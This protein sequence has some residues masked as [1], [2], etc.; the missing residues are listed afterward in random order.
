MVEDDVVRAHLVRARVR[1]RVR[2]GDRVRVRVWARVRVRVRVSRSTMSSFVMFTWA[3]WPTA[4]ALVAVSLAGAPPLVGGGT[5]GAVS[6][7]VPSAALA[8][9][10]TAATAAVAAVAAAPAAAVAAALS[11]V[12]VSVKA[13]WPQSPTSS[14]ALPVRCLRSRRWRIAPG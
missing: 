8:A 14:S 4:A 11:G 1:V 7:A 2:A 12:N 3:A 10:L 6:L 9:A 13:R 5:P